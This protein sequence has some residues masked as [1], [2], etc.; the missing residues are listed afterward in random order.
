VRI[1]DN[2]EHQVHGGRMPA[3]V[4]RDAECMIADMRD[5]NTLERALA[6]IDVVFHEAAAVGVGQSMYQIDK[7]VEVNSTGT[8]NLLQAILNRKGRV[9]K[10][11]VASSMSIY[12]EG[13]YVRADGAVIEATRT[14]RQL[15]SHDWEPECPATGLPVVPRPTR[16]T[17]PLRPS[18]IYAITKRDQEEMCL[19]FGQSYA[20]P[21]VALRYFNGYGPRQ[22]LSNPYTGVCAIF[23]S[24]YLNRQPP[25]I[26]EDG[27]QM[28]DFVHVRDIC[29]ANL[30]AMSDDRCNYRAF[31]VGSGS[32]IS[33]MALAGAIQKAVGS[34]CSPEVTSKF[35]QGDIRHCYADIS[36]LAALGYQPSVRIEDGIRDILESC[37]GAAVDRLATAWEELECRHLSL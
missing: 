24:R 12:G 28:R 19:V 23:C 18:S 31:N 3:Y 32:P 17:K 1:Y 20:I 37:E 22:C 4:N 2:L 25:L 16:E 11:I 35:R 13:E 8:A 36:E 30:L 6:G 26:Y 9:Q 15:K 10:L 33:I 7:Y 14:V 27:R 21:T 29:Q 34:E 5:R